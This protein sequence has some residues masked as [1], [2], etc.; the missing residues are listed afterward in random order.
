MDW[1]PFALALAA[2]L[3][4]HA[5]P[6]RPQI[7]ARLTAWLGPQGFTAGYSALSLGALIWVIR[8]AGQAPHVPV[9]PRTTA[10]IHC[11]LALMLGACVL[12][13]LAIGRPNPFSFGGAG[14]FDPT[15]PGLTRL[16]RHPLLAALALWA[17]AH[18][19]ANGDLAHV[20]L[21]GSFAT[22]ALI[23]PRL[24]DRRKRS[25][26]WQK[27]KSTVAQ[28]PLRSA[29]PLTANT[30]VRLAAALAIYGMLVWLHP[31]VIGVSPLP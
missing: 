30:L 12:I 7:K 3:V 25:P 26:D 6:V 16:T 9:W 21:F 2:F 31:M 11:A 5:L 18:M 1:L 23:G 29:L 4:S 14:Q 17:L 20:L 8:A 24:I 22:F 19:L 15:R 10:L 13:A 28:Q 27:L